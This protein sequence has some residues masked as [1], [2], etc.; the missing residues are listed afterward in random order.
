MKKFLPILASLCLTALL[1]GSAYALA[2][3][4]AVVEAAARPT[5]PPGHPGQGHGVGGNPGQGQG[6]GGNSGQGPRWGGPCGRPAGPQ[7]PDAAGEQAKVHYDGV[8]TAVD[9][10]SVTVATTL[11]G[12][13]T[14]DVNTTTCVRMPPSKGAALSDLAVGMRVGVQTVA[15]TGANPLAVRIHVHKPRKATHVG[16]VTAYTP[17]VSLSLLPEAG[18]SELTFALTAGTE[19]KPWHRAD[20]LAVGS[21]V[22]VQVL[23]DFAGPNPPVLR[24][25]V[26]GPDDDED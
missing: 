23:R 14:I 7:G 4:S 22:T 19:I 21:E 24:I 11:S 6:Q 10:A 26:H 1:F 5:K 13:I 3:P 20:E 25:N 16:T 9:A 2:E 18:G 17:G 15:G 12:T 8:L